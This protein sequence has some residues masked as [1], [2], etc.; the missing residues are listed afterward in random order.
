MDKQ[1]EFFHALKFKNETPGMCCVG[2]KVQLPELESPPEPL[3][4]L[5]SG[6]T[7]QSKQFLANICKYNSCFQMTSF[8]ATQIIRENYMPTFKIQGQIYHY[9]GSLLPMPNVEHKFLHIYFMG[10]TNEQINQRCRFN[11]NADREIIST[12]Q[13]FFV[14]HNALVRLFRTALEQMPSDDFAIVIKADK[15]LPVNMN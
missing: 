5:V 8:R 4:T 3:S 13:S 14:E 6:T 2:G 7:R 10:K 11:I 15:Y 1:C 9:S 12:L